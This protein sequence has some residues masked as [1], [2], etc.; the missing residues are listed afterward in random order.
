LVLL[1]F[2]MMILGM[3][4]IHRVALHQAWSRDIGTGRSYLFIMLALNAEVTP[5]LGASS[6]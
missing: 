3:Q 6:S 5:V 2:L 1:L 4:L